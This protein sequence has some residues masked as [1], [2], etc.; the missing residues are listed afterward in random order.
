M[1]SVLFREIVWEGKELPIDIHS[2]GR[3]QDGMG[4]LY[5]YRYNK[6][7]DCMVIE[8]LDRNGKVEER[9]FINKDGVVL[10]K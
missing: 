8:G 1:N 6:D 5:D 4:W 7:R 9:H 3:F 10:Y 2:Q